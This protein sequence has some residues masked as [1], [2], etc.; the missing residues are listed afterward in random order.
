M[1]NPFSSH[2]EVNLATIFVL[3]NE[4]SIIQKIAGSLQEA[5]YKVQ[6]ATTAQDAMTLLDQPPFPDLLILDFPMA[7]MDTSGFLNTLRQ[8]FGRIDLP[9]VLL[10]GD[11]DATGEAAANALQVQDYLQKPFAIETLLKHVQQLLVSGNDS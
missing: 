5:G 3:T 10:L 11:A 9:P 2:D 7:K 6:S 1:K 4:E 8:R